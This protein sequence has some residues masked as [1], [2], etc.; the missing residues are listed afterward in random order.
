MAERISYKTTPLLSSLLP[1]LG[2]FW[3][4]KCLIRVLIINIGNITT[5]VD[6]PLFQTQHINVILVASRTSFFFFF[7]NPNAQPSD[8]IILHLHLHAHD[9]CR[10]KYLAA[11]LSDRWQRRPPNNAVRNV[12]LR[13]PPSSLSRLFPLRTNN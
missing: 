5:V 12:S 3:S 6:H 8:N 1:W 9:L 11:L 10:C 4:S 2:S 7:P 13:I